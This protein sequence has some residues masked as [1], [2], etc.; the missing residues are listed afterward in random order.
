MSLLKGPG[1]RRLQYG[2]HTRTLDPFMGPA[3]IM[4][5][6]SISVG[7]INGPITA[8]RQRIHCV[9]EPSGVKR[10]SEL[11]QLPRRIT[12]ML[13]SSCPAFFSP[14]RKCSRTSPVLRS[15]RS[16]SSL[17]LYLVLSRS[18]PGLDF[19]NQCN[20]KML[21][22]VETHLPSLSL[23]PLFRPAKIPCPQQTTMYIE[24]EKP[25]RR[26]LRRKIQSK[27]NSFFQCTSRRNGNKPQPY[28][29]VL[30]MS[31]FAT[32]GRPP[33]QTKQIDAI[34]S[35]IHSRPLFAFPCIKKTPMLV[36]L[37]PAPC[38]SWYKRKFGVRRRSQNFRKSARHSCLHNKKKNQFS[39][40][41]VWMVVLKDYLGA[42]V[43]VLLRD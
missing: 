8:G 38:K 25:P 2:V 22:S 36:S 35:E 26:G 28:L 16:M 18:V 7:D 4:T 24:V 13:S 29:R 39:A 43:S 27:C 11:F 31:P 1:K 6:P 42:L 9:S 17:V 10:R 41:A 3:G 34:D 40:G 32:I 33:R 15:G 5:T 37:P 12:T 21:Q 20:L 23:P 19:R 30:F 14:I